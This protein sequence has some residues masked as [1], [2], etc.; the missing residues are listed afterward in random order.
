MILQSPNS[1]YSFTNIT[2]TVTTL[3]ADD[4]FNTVTNA[5]SGSTNSIATIESNVNIATLGIK[6][7]SG[8]TFTIVT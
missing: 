7:T 5:T 4:T 2:T 6:A 8:S 3:K 1:S